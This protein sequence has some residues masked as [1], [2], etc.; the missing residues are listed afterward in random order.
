MKIGSIEWTNER[1]WKR[2]QAVRR[3]DKYYMPFCDKYSQYFNSDGMLEAWRLP[4]DD[5][6]EREVKEIQD[7]YGLDIIYHYKVDHDIDDFHYDNVFE[8]PFAIDFLLKNEESDNLDPLWDNNHIVLKVNIDGSIPEAQLTD[9]L[10]E[11]VK[12]ARK[13]VDIKAVG[14]APKKIDYRVYDLLKL[15]KKP[16]EIIKEVWPDE[17]KIEFGEDEVVD[18]LEQNELIKKLVKEYQKQ[19]LQWGDAYDKAYKKYTKGRAVGK[20]NIGGRGRLYSKV[21]DA[22]N[23]VK[24][25]I[26]IIRK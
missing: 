18:D 25:Y 1:L 7:K 24:N 23:R 13:S 5:E 4:N 3:D 21:T 15:K 11:H 17:Y 26:D 9:E 20:K 10:L 2:W 16:R 12:E 19:G 8:N 6:A 14:S 22:N